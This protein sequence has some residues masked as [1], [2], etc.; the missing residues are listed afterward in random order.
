MNNHIKTLSNGDFEVRPL[1][2]AE[3]FAK[4]R[5]YEYEVDMNA[6][7]IDA[8]KELNLKVEAL[9]A[10]VEQMEKCPWDEWKPTKDIV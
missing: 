2:E 3:E 1:E 9:R 5:N 4:K 8:L 7:M 6:I 10:R